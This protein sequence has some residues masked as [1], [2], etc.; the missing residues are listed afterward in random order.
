MYFACL[1][2]LILIFLS[3]AQSIAD[4]LIQ[5]VEIPSSV[6][7]VGS[8]ARALGMGGAFIAVADDATAA[9][10]NP[11]GLIQLE[12]PEIS[13]VGAGFYRNED[14][15]FGMNPEASGNQ[16]VSES[17]LNYFSVA[18]PFT[19]FKLNMIASLNYQHLY[20]FSKSWDFKF[21]SIADDISIF[22]NV[23]FEQWGSL[24]AVGLAYAIQ[25]TPRMSLGLTL[26][27]WGDYV[28]Q[29]GWKKETD[30]CG[31]GRVDFGSGN[32]LDFTYTYYKKD[33]Y[34]FDGFNAN[35]G[36][37]W[38]ATPRLTIG[39]VLKTPFTADLAFDTE[40]RTSMS[41]PDFPGMDDVNFIHQSDDQELD[42]PMSY[43]IGAAWRFSDNLTASFDVYRTQ[44]DDFILEDSQGNK[45]NPITGKNADE[46]RLDPTHQVRLGAEYLF[47]GNKYVIP[48]R[49]G[50]FYDPAPTE[51][52]VD[53]FF[54][55]SI[56]S[57]IAYKR[58]I[59]DVAYQ[60]RFGRDV[61]KSYLKHLD[62]SQNVD[63]H[64]LYSLL[65]VHF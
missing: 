50:I 64:T 65:I 7:P 32:I 33:T 4:S 9:S 28:T 14:N 45:T 53:D 47:I 30:E 6:N 20:D 48:L 56:G 58:F 23:N 51:D 16:S 1:I 42:M 21:N 17:N 31:N 52:G 5:R 46:S 29:N 12:R 19:L 43:G 40:I 55:L 54:G 35:F 57:G 27:F 18:W 8:G 13:V 41:F 39:A 25:A 49:G 36:L 2:L 37:L 60:Y 62:F 22:R 26:N 44:W 59:F 61:G 63:E 11:G 15:N 3:P 38:N 10:W 34:S 24:S